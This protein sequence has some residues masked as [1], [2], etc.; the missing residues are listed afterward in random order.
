MTGNDVKYFNALSN[1]RFFEGEELVEYSI[2]HCRRRAAYGKLRILTDSPT[3]SIGTYSPHGQ[4]HY[5]P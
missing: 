5:P 4:W 3:V 1:A 2:R